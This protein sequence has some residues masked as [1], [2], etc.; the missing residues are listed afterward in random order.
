MFAIEKELL[1]EMTNDIEIVAYEED[2]I[3]D[4]DNILEDYVMGLDED[5]DDIQLED[6]ELSLFDLNDNLFNF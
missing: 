2:F 1:R 3:D 6:A 5:I 4:V